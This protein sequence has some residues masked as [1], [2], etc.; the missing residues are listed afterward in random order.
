MGGALGLLLGWWVTT[1]R[2]GPWTAL[3]CTALCFRLTPTSRPSRTPPFPP[4][5]WERSL[6]SFSKTFNVLTS[7]ARIVKI[8]LA[9]IYF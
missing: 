7:A 4:G 1:T 2:L 3:P 9:F 6:L 8:L 5:T